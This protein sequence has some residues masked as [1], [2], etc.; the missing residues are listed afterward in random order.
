MY[1]LTLASFKVWCVRKDNILENDTIKIRC[2]A[3]KII[4]I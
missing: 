3:K 4:D 2:R 1:D